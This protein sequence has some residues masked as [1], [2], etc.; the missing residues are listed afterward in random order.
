[1]GCT[2]T[3]SASHGLTLSRQEKPLE[4]L[5]FTV[6]INQ[7][8]S[9]CLTVRVCTPQGPIDGLKFHLADPWKNNFATNGVSIPFLGYP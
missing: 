3:G 8:S 1:M 5:I 7:S 2:H 6:S 4:V 9:L